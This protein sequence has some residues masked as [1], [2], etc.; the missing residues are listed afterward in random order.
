MDDPIPQLF[1]AYRLVA[2]FEDGRRLPFDGFTWEQAREAMEAAQIE[3]GDITWFDGVT[4]EHYE[5]GRYFAAVPPPP[6]SPFPI[7]DPTG[8]PDFEQQKLF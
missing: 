3:H 1:P 4:D 7:I 6:H 5:N 2:T 8:D